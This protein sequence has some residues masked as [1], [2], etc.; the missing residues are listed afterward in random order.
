MVVRI[1]ETLGLGQ[2]GDSLTIV[3]KVGGNHMSSPQSTLQ[4]PNSLGHG[5]ILSQSPSLV[6]SVSLSLSLFMMMMMMMMMI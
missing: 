3:I 1:L 2:M 5:P 6:W 4:T